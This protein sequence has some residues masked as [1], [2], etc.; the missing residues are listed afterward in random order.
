M[1]P[2]IVELGP[3]KKEALQLDERLFLEIEEY[4]GKKQALISLWRPRYADTGNEWDLLLWERQIKLALF[5]TQIYALLT[6][7]GAIIDFLQDRGV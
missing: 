1:T 6:H 2:K 5:K 7:N 3:G 4:R